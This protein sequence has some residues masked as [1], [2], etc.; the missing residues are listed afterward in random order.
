VLKSFWLFLFPIFLFAAQPKEFFLDELK[1]LEQRRHKC[2]ELRGEHVEK[3]R[4][5]NYI[6]CC[7]LYKTKDLS[8]P[9]IQCIPGAISM[10]M[11][12]PGR[13]TDHSPLFHAQ[14]ISTLSYSST[15]PYVFTM[16]CLIKHRNNIVE[17]VELLRILVRSNSIRG[18]ADKSLAL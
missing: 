15:P 12:R 3:I 5:L 6:A 10:A 1:K 17:F 14:I 11:K 7:F 18:R 2:V 9:P 8:A 4:F 13:E 16:W